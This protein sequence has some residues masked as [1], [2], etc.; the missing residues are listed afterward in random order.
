MPKPKEEPDTSVGYGSQF[1]ILKLKS[2]LM[3]SKALIVIE[4]QLNMDLSRMIFYANSSVIICAILLI[5]LC[6]H[7][8]SYYL[9]YIL[10]Q[11]H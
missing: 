11:D 8:L 4:F 10:V 7:L 5:Y 9:I 2:T 1:A 3:C 6:C